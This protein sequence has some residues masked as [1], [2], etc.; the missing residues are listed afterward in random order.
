MVSIPGL[1]GCAARG[2]DDH[3][4]QGAV[5]CSAQVPDALLQPELG[6]G[7]V[8]EEASAAAKGTSQ[9]RADCTPCYHLGQTNTGVIHFIMIMTVS[10]HREVALSRSMHQ[11]QTGLPACESGWVRQGSS[12]PAV[13]A[14][15]LAYQ[16]S[17]AWH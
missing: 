8:D 9:C 11:R 3:A 16:K 6:V 13:A 17:A 12:A 2:D 14:V 10:L 4:S 7:E 1:I 15:P 5:G